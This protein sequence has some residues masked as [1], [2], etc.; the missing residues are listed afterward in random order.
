MWV[1]VASM[2]GEVSRCSRRFW[3]HLVVTAV[4][5]DSQDITCYIL[6][7]TNAQGTRFPRYQGPKSAGA[8]N[9]ISD[10]SDRWRCMAC[11]PIVPIDSQG[12]TTYWCSSP[13]W[14]PHRIRL[15]AINLLW[16]LS[17]ISVSSLRPI[18]ITLT[19]WQ[20]QI[21]GPFQHN[22]NHDTVHA[23]LTQCPYHTR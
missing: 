9:T 10:T 7:S 2:N 5:I 16:Y 17:S 19:R 8:Q 13:C 11:M 14:H 12:M 4:P 3:A 1:I 20:K 22:Q 21:S 6:Y 18:T 23:Q 15:T